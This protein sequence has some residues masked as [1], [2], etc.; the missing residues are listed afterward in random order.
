VSAAAIRLFWPSAMQHCYTSQASPVVEL[1][2]RLSAS[3][4]RTATKLLNRFAA[5][6]DPPASALSVRWRD[7]TRSTA[8]TTLDAMT[9]A[10][11]TR[12]VNATRR[13]VYRVLKNVDRMA[14]YRVV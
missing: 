5:H 12:E 2:Q 14:P 6:L 13:Y 1:L 7:L 8:D 3:R 11:P 10:L 9:K 4:R